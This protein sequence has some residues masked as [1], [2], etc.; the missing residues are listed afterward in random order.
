MADDELADILG[1][2]DEPSW[3]PAERIEQMVALDESTLSVALR[4]LG[5]RR[6]ELGLSKLLA[7]EKNARD[8][9]YHLE[10]RRRE[11]R[12][13]V[14]AEE[15]ERKASEPL[16]VV[17][18]DELAEQLDKGELTPPTPTIG[19]L[20]YEGRVN[21]LFGDYTAGKTWVALHLAQLNAEERG[22]RT[23][24]ID[25]ED[26]A[27]GITARCRALDPKLP[28]SVTYVD[29]ST[30]ERLNVRELGYHVEELGITLVVIDSTG[31]S[32]AA[33]G[34]DGNADDDV[35]KWFRTVPY[36]IAHLGPAV[37]LLDHVPKKADGRPTPVGSFR[38]GAAI[39]GAQY[40]LVS[41]NGFSRVVA[42]S[43]QVI[44][45]KDRNGF[46]ATGEVVGR[47]LFT[48][49]EEAE[50][51]AVELQRTNG[52]ESSVAQLDK[53]QNAILLYV[54]DRMATVHGQLDEN[55][56]EMDGR[57]SI[58]QIREA[59]K[60]DMQVH[61]AKVRAAVDDL[62]ET[63]WLELEHMKSGKSTR[64]VYVPSTPREAF[65]DA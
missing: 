24:F 5:R 27:L 14:D 39:T 40:A 47:V 50:K 8:L 19:G 23:L 54:R 18:L 43:S 59:V 64:D 25:Y 36:A 20:L 4:E 35:A 51:L 48:P 22:G 12:A 16:D 49:D 32:L 38:K 34:A 46:F 37:L 65:D 55:D 13:R 17:P 44:C 26:S 3:V 2:P 15:E 7:D 11:A 9:E 21:A 52:A 61:N 1:E 41:K 28:H 30:I 53:L 31:M 29:G 6:P 60:K 42:G 45:T 10:R 56:Q 58:T 63:G 62:V 33:E 57:P